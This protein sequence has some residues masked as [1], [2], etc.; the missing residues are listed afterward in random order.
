MSEKEHVVVDVEQIMAEIRRDIQMRE[1][2]KKLPAFG[3]IPLRGEAGKTEQAERIEMKDEFIRPEEQ[4]NWKVL[5]EALMRANRE[6]DIPYYWDFGHGVKGFVKRVVR[7]A[8]KCLLAPIVQKQ[9][10]FNADT[11]RVLNNLNHGMKELYARADAQAKMLENAQL[12]IEKYRNAAAKEMDCAVMAAQQADDFNKYAQTGEDS[13]VRFIFGMLGYG[14]KEVTY[15]DIGAN[16]ARELSNTY[17]FYQKGASGV[18]VEADPNLIPELQIF[19]RRDVI[20]NRCISDVS[21]ETVDFYVMSNDGLSSQNRDSIDHAFSVDKDVQVVQVVRVKTITIQEI[22]KEYFAQPPML[23]SIDVEGCEML[24]LRGIDFEKCRPV[25]IVVETIPYEN[26]L[27]VGEKNEELISFMQEK[28]YVEYAFTGVNSI[29]ID[30]ERLGKKEIRIAKNPDG[31]DSSQDYTLDMLLNDQAFR[32]PQGIILKAN[33]IAYGPYITC[34][35]GNYQVEVEVALYD[36]KTPVNLEILANTEEEKI[37]QFRLT[38]GVNRF[39]FTLSEEKHRVE[40][41]VINQT[42]S[43]LCVRRVKLC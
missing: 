15:L 23:L 2:Q 30:K 3:D 1:D 6:Y 13:I 14:A 39:K 26:A 43:E 5:Q 12:T 32:S 41:R 21:D 34:R 38:Q 35:P 8:L 4:V 9:N 29:F 22:L 42:S 16:H 17:Y 10:R 19:R 28:G 36:G 33:G 18:L 40:F 7:K 37:A 31:F 24:V 20:L 11:V 27:V 25:V